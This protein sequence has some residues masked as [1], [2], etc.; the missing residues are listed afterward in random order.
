MKKTIVKT[1][2]TNSTAISA[3]VSKTSILL[4]TLV[5]L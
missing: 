5:P 3:R 4:F 2:S 1:A